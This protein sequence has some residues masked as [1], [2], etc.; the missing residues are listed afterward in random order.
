ML[1]QRRAPA[2]QFGNVQEGE[3]VGE[4]G[5]EAVARDLVAPVGEFVGGDDVGAVGEDGVDG[6]AGGAAPVFDVWIGLVRVEV[7]FAL[8]G[9]L[10]FVK[11]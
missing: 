3:P 4:Q 7:A 10:T 1:W 8:C 11:K 6:G 5:V 9:V 2:L